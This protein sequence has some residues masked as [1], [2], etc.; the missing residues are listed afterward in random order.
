MTKQE[1]KREKILEV[2]MQVFNN[3]GF[4]KAKITDIAKLAGIATGSIYL[5]FKDKNEIIEEIF[6]QTWSRLATQISLLHSD[7]N[8][9]CMHKIL[10]ISMY[11]TELIRENHNRAILVLHEHRFWNSP[12]TPKLSASVREFSEKLNQIVSIGS[13]TGEFRPTI[14]PS[15]AIPF[16]IGGV[17]HLLEHWADNFDELPHDVVKNQI[18]ELVENTLL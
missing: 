3:V 1:I 11:L 5:Y 18:C 15:I 6:T 4:H 17:G 12:D 16:L 13:K 2:A 14:V 9:D 10:A 7:N 8:L